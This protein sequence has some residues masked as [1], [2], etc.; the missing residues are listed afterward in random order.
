MNDVYRSI[1]PPGVYPSFI[2]DISLDPAN[3][4][5]NIHPAKKEVRITQESKIISMVR[6]LVEYTLM[7]FGGTKS[8]EN[9]SFEQGLPAEKI[10]YGPGPSQSNFS[11]SS[12][13]TTITQ[14]EHLP[15]NNQLADLFQSTSVSM[16]EKFARSK[17]I[18]SFN[19]KFLLFEEGSSLLCVDQHAAQERIMFERF[20][21]QIENNTIEVQPLL[22]PVLIKLNL[23]ETLSLE[24]YEA[25]LKEVGIDASLLDENTLAIHSQ[26]S[27]LKNIESAVRTLLN[28]DDIARCDRNTLARRAC[29]ASIVAGDH[30]SPIQVENQRKELL[31]CADPFTC[32]HGRPI[33]IELT[34]SFL[35][36]QF[37]RI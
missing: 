7:R 24:S 8:L 13:P 25:K 36:K 32:P 10:I 17:Y 5:S 1:L 31:A 4:D 33:I 19:N 16:S 34:E 11:F 14:I 21:Q 18:G 27:L 15:A 29:K 22:T 6:H 37:L 20:C 9:I 3:V 26:P 12:N 30:L 28:G 23:K 2:L 35:D